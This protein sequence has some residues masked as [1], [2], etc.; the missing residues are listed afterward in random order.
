MPAPKVARSN[1]YVVVRPTAPIRTPLSAGPA[2]DANDPEML[3]STDAA[4]IF[5]TGTSL[6]VIER[7]PPMPRQKNDAEKNASTKQAH[8]R[9]CARAA[10]TSRPIPTTA[11]PSCVQIRRRRRSSASASAPPISVSVTSGTS[12]TNEIAATASVDPVSW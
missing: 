10:F 5:S 2:T 9:G 1:A 3:S 4:G 6:G 7:M 12:S 8:T 11:I